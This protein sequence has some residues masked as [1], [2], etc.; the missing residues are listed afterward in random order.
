MGRRDKGPGGEGRGPG[1]GA[2]SA[3]D[4]FLNGDPADLP[5]QRNGVTEMPQSSRCIWRDA[6]G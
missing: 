4:C 3:Q 2:V 6:R 1:E 5:G